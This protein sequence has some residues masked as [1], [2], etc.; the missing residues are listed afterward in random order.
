[1]YVPLCSF[2]VVVVF[3][4]QVS[5]NTRI[6]ITLELRCSFLRALQLDAIETR[7]QEVCQITSVTRSGGEDTGQSQD[8]QSEDCLSQAVKQGR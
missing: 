3:F 5:L 1:M 6:N 7:S 2:V 4:W 8:L